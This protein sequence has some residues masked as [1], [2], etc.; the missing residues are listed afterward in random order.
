MIN[1]RYLYID[2]WKVLGTIRSELFGKN[3]IQHVH[4]YTEIHETSRT[5]T[6]A[7]QFCNAKAR[8]RSVDRLALF[9]YFLLKSTPLR[10]LNMFFSG[11]SDRMFQKVFFSFLLLRLSL[12]ISPTFFDRDYINP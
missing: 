4:T 6:S 2:V 3:I 1:F 8:D 7:Q 5:E 10:A 9:I 12:N 11:W